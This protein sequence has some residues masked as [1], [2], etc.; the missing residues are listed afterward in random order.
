[1]KEIFFSVGHL[2]PRYVLVRNF[3]PRN[4]SEGYFFLKS[5]LPLPPPPSKVKWSSRS[6]YLRPDLRH[7]SDARD[8]TQWRTQT[9]KLSRASFTWSKWIE[10][11][12]AVLCIRCRC[13]CFGAGYSPLKN[14]VYF[15]TRYQRDLPGLRT[16]RP[17]QVYSSLFTIPWRWHDVWCPKRNH[18]GRCFENQWMAFKKQFRSNIH[19]LG[20]NDRQGFWSKTRKV[21]EKKFSTDWWYITKLSQA[22]P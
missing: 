21:Y 12:K 18:V 3:F 16:Q 6:P 9:L 15:W 4:L 14:I 17:S 8:R 22:R 5:P 13:C 10:I 20:R 2:F 11:G 19:F 1:M 7:V